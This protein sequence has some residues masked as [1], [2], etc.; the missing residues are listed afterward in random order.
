MKIMAN[1]TR[2]RPDKK[3]ITIILALIVIYL[4]L[5]SL[6]KHSDFL[7]VSYMS[8]SFALY[9][10]GFIDAINGQTDYPPTFFIIDG[11]WIKLGSIVFSINLNDIMQDPLNPSSYPWIFPLWG[12]IPDLLC[13]IAFVAAAFY[14]LKNKWLTLICFG[15]LSFVSV[16]IMGQIDIFYAFFIFLSMLCMLK[17]INSDHRKSYYLLSLIMLGLSLQFKMFGALLLPIYLLFIINS[18]IVKKADIITTATD[19]FT[20]GLSFLV[21]GFFAWV[22]FVTWFRPIML[23]GESGWLFN[24]QLSPVDLPF[25]TISLWL[26]GYIVILYYLWYNIRKSSEKVYQDRRYF[27]FVSFATVAWFFVAVYSHP[28]W[29]VLLLP[30]IL[31]VL[32]NFQNEDN[33]LFTLILM[34]LALFYATMWSAITDV[35]RGYLPTFQISGQL[36]MLLWTSMAGLLTIWILDLGLSLRDDPEPVAGHTG[37]SANYAKIFRWLAP[38]TILLLPFIIFSLAGLILGLII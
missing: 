32:D 18:C 36:T 29:W 26:L 11:T 28:Q 19:L 15:T 24:L 5:S 30:P 27:V 12:M 1:I 14:A 22:P 20:Y 21:A 31:L 17:A 16:I 3:I 2:A 7:S 33:Y 9:G 4:L 37:K 34:T 35:L 10:T 23:G 6:P 8:T 25:H 13:L 38:V